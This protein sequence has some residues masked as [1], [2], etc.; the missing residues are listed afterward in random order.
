LYA[1][2]SS[3]ASKR[4]VY[5]AFMISQISRVGTGLAKIKSH[6]PPVMQMKKMGRDQN[7]GVVVE[8]TESLT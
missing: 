4:S 7:S 6:S 2:I 8:T 5:S 3:A 1:T